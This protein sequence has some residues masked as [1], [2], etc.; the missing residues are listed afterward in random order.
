MKEFFSKYSYGMIKMFVNQF[1]ISI[2]GSVLAMATATAGNDT[3]TLVVSGF[4][5]LFYLFLIYTMT[6]EIGAKDKITVDVGKKEY[7]PFTGLWMAL[8]ANIPNFII[9]IMH[10]IAFPMMATA[11]WAGNL[12]AV[13]RFASVII[14]GMYLGL[15]STVQIAGTQMN[16]LWWTYFVI[17]IPALVTSWLAYYLGH[18]N[19]RFF[20]RFTQAKTNN[21]T[22]K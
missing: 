9:A 14:Q 1:A 18:K 11:Q 2:F 4:S 5:I 19:F 8:I 16:Q 3:L 10:T 15:T 17:I 22:N 13:S 20:A 21:N 7:R 6:W 12:G